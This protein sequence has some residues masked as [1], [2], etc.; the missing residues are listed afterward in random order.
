MIII[1]VF[2]RNSAIK[3]V[4]PKGDAMNYGNMYGIPRNFIRCD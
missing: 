4:I 1:V 2:Y 3:R